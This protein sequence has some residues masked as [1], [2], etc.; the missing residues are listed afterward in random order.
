MRAFFDVFINSP[1]NRS[2]KACS[3]WTEKLL[4]SWYGRWPAPI[5]LHSLESS[6]CICIEDILFASKS[7]R[8]TFP[9]L[10]RGMKSRAE[11]YGGRPTSWAY[12]SQILAKENLLTCNFYAKEGFT[13]SKLVGRKIAY[14]L[15]FSP[16]WAKLPPSRILFLSL[17]RRKN[18]TD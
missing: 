10:H 4:Y 3:R 14:N 7:P 17:N 15:T 9:M 6:R 11:R 8:E 2:S 13:L 5:F 1:I 18:D 12:P 16:F